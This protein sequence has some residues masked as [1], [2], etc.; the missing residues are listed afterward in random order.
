MIA[1]ASSAQAQCNSLTNQCCS[2]SPSYSPGCSDESCCTAVCAVDS[3]CCSTYWDEACA[4]GAVVLC[5]DVCGNGPCELGKSTIVEDEPCGEERNNTCFGG[6]LQTIE[7]GDIL[8]GN[9]GANAGRDVDWFT[10]VL[11]EP[12][13]VSLSLRASRSIPLKA[14]ITDATCLVGLF[15]GTSGSCPGEVTVCL[16]AGDYAIAVYPEGFDL[17]QCGSSNALYTLELSGQPGCSTAAPANDNCV[18]AAVATIGV[19]PFNTVFATTEVFDVSCNFKNVA[20]TNEV[21]FSFTATSGGLHE[22]GTCGNQRSFD[23]GIELWSACPASGGTILACDDNGCSVGTSALTSRV[24]YPMESGETVLIRLGGVAGVTGVGSLT[25]DRFGGPVSCGGPN[26]GDCCEANIAPGC[27]DETCCALVCVV[28]E[29]CCVFAWDQSCADFASSLCSQSCSERCKLPAGTGFEG[30]PCGADFNGG[31]NGGSFNAIEIGDTVRGTFWADDFVRDTDWYQLELFEPTEVTVTIRSALRSFAAFVDS[32]CEGGLLS[33]T[34]GECPGT[35][36]RCFAPGV[37]YIVALPLDFDGAPCGSGALNDYALEVSGVPGCSTAPPANDSCAAAGVAT[38]GSNPFDTT[39]ATTEVLQI[40]CGFNKTPFEKDVWF[41]FTAT[42]TA[43]YTFETCGAPR[44]FDSGIEIWDGCPS[45]GGEVVACNDDGCQSLASSV[46]YPLDSGE[47]VRIRIGGQGGSSDKASLTIR[48]GCCGGGC[49]GCSNPTVVTVGS[50]AFSNVRTN[51][52][53]EDGCGLFGGFTSNVNFYR[54]TP[55]QSGAYRISTCDS[56]GFDTVISVR[57]GCNGTTLACNDNV[58]EQQCSGKTSLIPSVALEAGVPYIITIGSN[59]SFGLG[60]GVL[61]ISPVG[62][63]STPANDECANATEV[64]AGTNS[65]S[66][67]RATGNVFSVCG[68]LQRS[69][70]YA[71]TATADGTAIISFCD[72]DGGATALNTVI[73]VIRSC[74]DQ[75]TVACSNDS[76]SVRSK[77]TFDTVCGTRYLFAIGSRGGSLPA[78]GTGTF[79]VTQQ[80]TCTPPCPADIDGDGEVSSSDLGALLSAWGT[81]AADLDSDGETGSSDLGVLLSAW[82]PCP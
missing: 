73:Q 38:L 58:S 6:A 17:A 43:V 44:V 16:D 24:V 23:T 14:V 54:F 69:V 50:N 11:A 64:F 30:E 61:D 65:F 9:I 82:G 35:M 32:D 5:G 74:D 56:V 25:I 37:Y 81:P 41:T 72:A 51:C 68:S 36:S 67:V 10:F 18:D 13:R 42:E 70:W 27:A 20:F 76:C 80:G 26:A 2:P 22:F 53:L 62:G 21:W 31:C 7:I 34:E 55:P 15:A 79:T 59:D 33:V 63:G 40:T 48:S 29:L 49:D 60:E 28:D 8:A 1:A 66:N 77:V 45:E 46:S 4:L 71:Y 3:Y 47:S 57:T 52:L 12:T 78:T 19:N 75:A 39:F